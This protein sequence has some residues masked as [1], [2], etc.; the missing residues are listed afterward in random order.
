MQNEAEAIILVFADA[1]DTWCE[2]TASVSEVP[3]DLS[4][5]WMHDLYLHAN[6]PLAFEAISIAMG[7]SH[8]KDIKKEFDQI[9]KLAAESDLID[10]SDLSFYRAKQDAYETCHFAARDLAESLRNRLAIIG[11]KKASEIPPAPKLAL[12]HK[13][14]RDGILSEGEFM[15]ASWFNGYPEP[16]SLR[17]AKKT[18]RIRSKK[19]GNNPRSHNLY[20]V[21]DAKKIWP[22]HKSKWGDFT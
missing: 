2:S 8:S 9:Y 3:R 22:E 10:D 1:I 20:S 12:T 11:V 7:P 18:G 19:A 14:P 16:D 15:K 6:A 13:E 21:E 5:K 4:N 17:Q